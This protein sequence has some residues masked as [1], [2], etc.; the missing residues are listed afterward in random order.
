M[1]E[2]KIDRERE[3]AGTRGDDRGGCAIRGNVNWGDLLRN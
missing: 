3:R 1:S 2:S